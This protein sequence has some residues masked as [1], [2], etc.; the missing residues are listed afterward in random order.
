MKLLVS[1][2]ITLGSYAG[3]HLGEFFGIMAAFLISGVGS[4]AGVYVGWRAAR[5]LSLE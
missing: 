4:I 3:W 2:G 1:V 5:A